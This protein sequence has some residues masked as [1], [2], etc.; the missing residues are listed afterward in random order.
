MRHVNLSPLPDF[1]NVHEGRET[2]EPKN[3]R[4]DELK[5]GRKRRPES[6]GG[7]LRAEGRKSL[8]L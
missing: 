4:T 1:Q 6:L 5:N 8:L 2:K 7:A 3:R